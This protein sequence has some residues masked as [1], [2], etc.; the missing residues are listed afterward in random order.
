MLNV[1]L[2][3]EE[4]LY[5]QKVVKINKYGFEQWRNLIITNKALYNFEKKSLKRR[6]DIVDIMGITSNKLTEEFVIHC[7]DKE[8]DYFYK[9]PE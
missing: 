3:D 7:R 1:K 5:S 2:L 8:Y 4:L 9:V 6:I